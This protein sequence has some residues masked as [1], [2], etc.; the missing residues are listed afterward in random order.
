[1]KIMQKTIFTLM[2]CSGVVQASNST[3]YAGQELRSVKALSVTE[4]EGLLAGK[5][6]GMAK[7]AEL[8]HYPGP[9][10]VLEVKKDLGLSQEQQQQTEQ[11]FNAMKKE[12]VRVGQLI[13]DEEQ[14]LDQLFSSTTIT[15]EQL[16]SG[17]VKLAK[18]RGELRYIHLRTHLKQKAVLSKEQIQHYDRLRGYRSHN[19]HHGH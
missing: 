5:G 16:K 2:L 6:M 4:I 18:L 3:P 8:N 19:G 1:M 7:A 14:R 9:I 17:L 13:I 12:A 10:H 11:L 15:D